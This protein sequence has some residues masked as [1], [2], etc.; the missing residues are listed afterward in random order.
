MMF[1]ASRKQKI[2]HVNQ[3]GIYLH[4]LSKSLNIISFNT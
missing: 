2:I 1:F 3:H 4:Q